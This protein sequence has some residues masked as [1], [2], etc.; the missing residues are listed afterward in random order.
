MQR[1][2]EG[3]LRQVR[4][5]V[6]S[7]PPLASPTGADTTSDALSH[8]DQGVS[9]G[10]ADRRH[11]L[12]SVQ[13]AR[14]P[15]CLRGLRGAPRAPFTLAGKI[16]AGDVR[17]VRQAVV[18][19]LVGGAIIVPVASAEVPTISLLAAVDGRGSVGAGVPTA[20]LRG[21][22]WAYRKGGVGVV[23]VTSSL[24]CSR[25]AGKRINSSVPPQTFSMKPNTR[26]LVWQRKNVV[27]CRLSITASGPGR[28][29][30]TLR[31]Y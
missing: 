29:R 21:Q 26:R 11:S 10:L 4:L 5:S 9:E 19:L 23:T 17:I 14:S 25:S 15:S 22:V 6:V 27:S 24:L 8:R 28:L 1:L 12:T 13:S 30:L 2:R 3:P 20:Q 31:G 18:T 16:V 7:S